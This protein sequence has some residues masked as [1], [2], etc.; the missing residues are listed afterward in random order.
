MSSHKK[1]IIGIS[2]V[3][4][5][6]GVFVLFFLLLGPPKLLAKTDTP[7]FCVSCHVMEAEYEAWFHSGAHSR[8]KCT[9]CHLPNQNLAAHYVWKAVD[10]FKE[11]VIFHTGKVPEQII[12][13]SHGMNVLQQNCIRCH[14]AA[15][16]MMDQER[17]CWK[18]H[19]GITHKLTGTI[20][21]L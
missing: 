18:C 2:V 15:V 8:A 1:R 12:L 21:T 9:D 14:E 10:G 3:L 4:L 13:S 6:A 16:T 5:V 17:R 11:V 20:E 7:G 19:R